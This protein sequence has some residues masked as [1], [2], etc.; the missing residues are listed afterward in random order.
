[1]KRWLMY[2]FRTKSIPHND[3]VERAFCNQAGQ[4]GHMMCGFC[5][6][7]KPTWNCAAK[8]CNPYLH[9]AKGA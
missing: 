8:E 9:K 2:V 1:M 5:K 4:I 3:D 7:N 6:H